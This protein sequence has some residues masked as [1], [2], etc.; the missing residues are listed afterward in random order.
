[1]SK[2]R[3]LLVALM[4]ALLG[5][6]SP[7]N[8][9][10]STQTSH[11]T[12]PL[13]TQALPFSVGEHLSFRLRYG[14]VTAG[15]AEMKVL[16]LVEKDGD[17]YLQFQSTARS[18]RTFDWFYKVRDVVNSFVNPSTLLPV[19]FEKRL[20]EGGY[21]ADTF[22]DYFQNDSLAEITFIR[23]TDNMKIKKKETYRVKIPYG[24]HDALSSLYFV[25]TF[26]LLP[27]DSV[28]IIAHEKK[29]VYPLR[30][31]VLKRETIHVRAGTF[32]C[33]QIEPRLAGEGI[34]KHKGRLRIWLTDDSLK[35]PVQMTT[36]VIVGHITAEL[37]SI[38]GISV[39]IPARLKK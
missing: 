30:I 22:V 26:S 38:K 19:R 4:F 27:G 13:V 31:D 28:F 18:S 35:I 5:I 33:V 1:M 23:Y 25:R 34:F 10:D 21:K 32:R 15:S 6:F 29:K 16:P 8:A 2:G 11:L 37:T 9:Q 36:E 20:R 12:H 3:I 24:V 17:A 39:P 14:F 7:L